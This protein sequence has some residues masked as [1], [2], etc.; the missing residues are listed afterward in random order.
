MADVSGGMWCAIAI[1]AALRR[2][3]ATGEGEV[4]DIAM[5]DGVLGF[6]A[7]QISGAL[8]GD[9]VKRGAEILTGGIAPYNTYLSKDGAPMSLAPL[10]PKFWLKFAALTG[11]EADVSALLPG[12]HQPA[13]TAKVREVVAS[14]TRAEWEAFCAE[15]DV[16]I[17]PILTG[18][19]IRN[20]PQL[21]ARELF[22]D[23]EHQGASLTVFRTPV[24]DRRHVPGPAPEK[25]E[26][27]RAML[28]E[29]GFSATEIDSLVAAG[30][31]HT[32]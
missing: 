22:F 17:E 18:D 29:A 19:E 12:A 2:R 21:A 23:L 10:E 11:L 25:G 15:H 7:L 3:D 5:T 6:A 27:T 8:N 32:R 26:H 14:K 4:C 13:L 9:E 30:A 24:S 16:L 31:I 1:L 20:D 28:E